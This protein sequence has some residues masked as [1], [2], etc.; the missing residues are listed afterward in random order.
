MKP[1]EYMNI[2]VWGGEVS[3]RVRV[4][5]SGPALVYLHPAGGLVWDAFLERLSDSYTVYSPEFPGTTP[6]DPYAVKK[7]DE[8]QDVVYAYEEA[9]RKLG[10]TRP[11]LVGQSFG[12]MLAAELSSVFP[13]LPSRL[14]ILDAIGLWRDD[15]P[16]VNWNELPATDMPALLFHDPQSAGA[17]AMLRLPEDDEERIKAMAAGVWTLGCTGKFVWPIPDLGLSKRLH[18]VSVPALIIWGEHDRLVPVAYAGE[19]AKR[20]EGSRVCVIPHAGHI[21][22]VENLEPTLVATIDFLGAA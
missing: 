20:I 11:I 7:F 2:D 1:Y 12:G 18:R 8:L 9:I 5:G 13:D 17:Q 10:L 21:P 19:F 14:V 15:V 6:D 4:A 22:Q 16:V 3:L